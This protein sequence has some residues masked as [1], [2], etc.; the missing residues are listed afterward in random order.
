[1][2]CNK[3]NKIFF[4]NTVQTLVDLENSNR[5]KLNLLT[6]IHFHAHNRQKQ[7]ARQNKKTNF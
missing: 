6:R 2:F 4:A 7:E 5:T 3:D 1:M